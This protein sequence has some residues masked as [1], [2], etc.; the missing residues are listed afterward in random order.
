VAK[1]WLYEEDHRFYLGPAVHGLTLASG[2]IRAGMVTHADLAALHE[3][4]GG[5]VFLGVGAGDHLIYI[6]EAGSDAMAG[7]EARSNI[8]RTLL[9]T[10]GGKALLAA[11]PDAELRAFLR[12]HS[13]EE[14]AQVDAFLG[15]YEEIR[16]TRIATNLRLAGTRFAIGTAVRDKSGEAVASITLVGRTPDLQPRMKKLS[17]LLLRHVDSWSQRSLTPREA[18]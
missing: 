10:A 14:A 6:A 11:R 3:A 7:I 9:S 2:Q 16:K 5:A 8:R 15:E 17:G 4:T 13:A 18:I 1:G 12:R